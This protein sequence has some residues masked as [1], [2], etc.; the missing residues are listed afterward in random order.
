MKNLSDVITRDTLKCCIITR[1]YNIDN[2]VVEIILLRFRNV[3]DTSTSFFTFDVRHDNN[4]N[5]IDLLSKVVN[6]TDGKSIPTL[7]ELTSEDCVLLKEE[8]YDMIK[9]RSKCQ[10]ET[11]GSISNKFTE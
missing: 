1:S 6:V 9:Y 7:H 10:E 2:K 8:Y 5:D 3:E 11:N 4:Q